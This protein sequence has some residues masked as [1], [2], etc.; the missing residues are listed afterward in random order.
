MLVETPS[1][2]ARNYAGDRYSLDATKANEILLGPNVTGGSLVFRYK[3]YTQG[4]NNYFL[5]K[6][7]EYFVRESINAEI[8]T[9]YV[10]VPVF[11]TEEALFNRAEANIM[12]NNIDDALSD[13][14]AYAS[15]RIYNYDA[16]A[17]SIT[18]NK[19]K[20]FYR[21]SNVQLGALQAL[22]DLKRAEF[23][24]EGMRWFDLL[25]Y[26]VP[27]QHKTAEGTT[28]AL[29]ATDPMRVFQIPATAKLAG[30]DLNPR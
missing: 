26:K 2:W 14:N 23:V 28:L 13:L 12:L 27:V 8:G 11:T 25:R 29:S 5:P 18:A 15:T 10:M 22:M 20:S 19:I 7:H 17:H 16:S 24:Q 9:G 21:T 4:T 3:L 1:W 30:I 6:V